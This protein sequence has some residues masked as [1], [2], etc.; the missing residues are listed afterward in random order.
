[1]VFF[2]CLGV[3]SSYTVLYPSKGARTYG[4]IGYGTLPIH[5]VLYPGHSLVPTSPWSHMFGTHE[6]IN[7]SPNPELLQQI[8][9]NI[10]RILVL[11][12]FATNLWAIMYMYPSFNKVVRQK[13]N[14]RY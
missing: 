2:E 14:A 1:M 5:I 12:N 9:T 7:L 13:L 8:W 4:T 6:S 3:V 10:K 11:P